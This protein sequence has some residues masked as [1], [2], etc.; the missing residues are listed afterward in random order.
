MPKP[1]KGAV[2]IVLSALTP[3]TVEGTR[4]SPGPGPGLARARKEPALNQVDVTAPYVGN[5]SRNTPELAELQRT[6][7]PYSPKMRTSYCPKMRTP[8]SPRMRTPYSPTMRTP[9]CRKM[10]TPYYP[11]MRTPYFPKMRTPSS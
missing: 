3:P 5:Y 9:Y 7:V 2:A 6:C 4:Y 8:Y 10:R 11:K 1:Q